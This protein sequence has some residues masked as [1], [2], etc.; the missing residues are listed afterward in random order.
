MSAV[1]DGRRPEEAL[2]KDIGPVNSIISPRSLSM[3]SIG[4]E[5][6]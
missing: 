4:H 2:M 5:M 6:E 1:R 3:P